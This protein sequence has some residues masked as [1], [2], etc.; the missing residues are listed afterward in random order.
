MANLRLMLILG[1]RFYEACS[2]CLVLF[3]IQYIFMV[4]FRVMARPMRH[5]RLRV[6]C[7][8]FIFLFLK[9]QFW[10][11]AKARVGVFATYLSS[12]FVLL[13]SWDLLLVLKLWVQHFCNLFKLCAPQQPISSIYRK[14]V[15][16]VLRIQQLLQL[17]LEICSRGE[18]FQLFVFLT[19]FCQ[20]LGVWIILVEF[21]YLLFKGRSLCR[22]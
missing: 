9:T 11:K 17:G 21:V 2:S 14:T 12:P 16:L 7:R 5:L 3:F 20:G 8:I 13:L 15:G 6:L 1:L 22:F 18:L 19:F 4:M 10:M